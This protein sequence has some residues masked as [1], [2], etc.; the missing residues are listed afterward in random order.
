MPKEKNLKPVLTLPKSV[1]LKCNKPPEKEY[2][3]LVELTRSIL[4]MLI[5][6]NIPIRYALSILE[7]AK[8][9]IQADFEFR[10]ST[11]DFILSPHEGPDS[12]Q[13]EYE[14]DHPNAG[15]PA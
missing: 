8:R 11:G 7:Q 4:S 10:I 1:S 6:A 15:V 2:L 12:D 13:G 5:D 3:R 9:E 14:P